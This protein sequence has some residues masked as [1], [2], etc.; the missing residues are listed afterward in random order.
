M[1]VAI[2]QPYFLPYIGYF[3]LIANSDL[4]IL[5]DNI[6]YT[7]KGWINRNRF[8][9]NGAD[10]TFSLP[11]RK[12]SDSLDIVDRELATDFDRERLLNQLAGAYRKAPEF[13][14]TLALLERIVRCEEQNLFRYIAYSIRVIC[15]HLGIITDIKVSSQIAA[16]HS[17]R[18]QGRVLSI[19]KAVGAATYLNAPGGRALYD[20][21][22]FA[23]HN[24]KLE[25]LAPV[26]ESYPQ[27]G[28]PF[29]PALSVVDVMMFNSLEKV[30]AAVHAT[31]AHSHRA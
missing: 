16:T 13:S 11:L 22:I 3:Q 7:K 24:I 25:F 29:L 17:L 5:Y 4:F 12:A 19:C 26:I 18:G 14:V 31:A 20:G 8:L 28:A 15:E 2:M 6:K 23:E 27:L 1:R 9:L 30:R 21:E 10:A